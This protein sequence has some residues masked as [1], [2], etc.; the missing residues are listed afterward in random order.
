VLDVGREAIANLE[1]PPQEI[2]IDGH[3]ARLMRVSRTRG[4]EALNA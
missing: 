3:A 1:E 2:A 4:L